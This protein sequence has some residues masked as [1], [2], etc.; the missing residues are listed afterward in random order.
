MADGL[1]M[2][3]QSALLNQP[4]FVT[5]HPLLP[6]LSPHLF[7]L[8]DGKEAWSEYL[9]ASWGNSWGIFATTNASFDECQKHFERVL[10]VKA[11]DGELLFFRYYDPRVLRTFLAGCSTAQLKTFF[12]PV[13]VFTVEDR[14][15]AY[16]ISFWLQNNALCSNRIPATDFFARLTSKDYLEKQKV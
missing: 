16:A 4:L 13:K 8:P 3:R 1:N 9:A 15:P 12:G 6:E 10:I 2:M 5:G 7:I 11:S 14:D